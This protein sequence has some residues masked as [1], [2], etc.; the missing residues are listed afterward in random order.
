MIPD[1]TNNTLIGSQI[2]VIKQIRSQSICRKKNI[3]ITTWSFCV[4]TRMKAGQVGGVTLQA[5][6]VLIHV[7]EGQCEETAHSSPSQR[8]SSFQHLQINIT[9]VLVKIWVLILK[10]TSRVWWE[11]KHDKYRLL[12]QPTYFLTAAIAPRVQIWQ[13]H[14][15]KI[16]PLASDVWGGSQS[17][18]PH[19]CWKRDVH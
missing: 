7:V 12:R 10:W 16:C 14:V 4:I 13:N 8:H 3:Y 2:S 9:D 11:I 18:P 15:L 5:A 17:L 1:Y 6:T 19:W